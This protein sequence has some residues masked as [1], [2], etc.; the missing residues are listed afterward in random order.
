[1]FGETPN[2]ARGTRALPQPQVVAI[3]YNT[4]CNWPGKRLRDFNKDIGNVYKAIQAFT[5]LNKDIQGYPEIK[6]FTMLGAI[7]GFQCS[8]EPP[9]PSGVSCKAT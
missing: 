9:C 2:T 8:V 4:N 1:M 7:S 6:K 5:R 3:E